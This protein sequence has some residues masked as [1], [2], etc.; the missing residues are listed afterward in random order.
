MLVSVTEIQTWLRCRRQHYLSSLSKENLTPITPKPALALGSLIHKAG[1]L[2]ILDENPTSTPTKFKDIFISQAAQARLAFANL[3]LSTFN[4]LPTQSEQD[5]LL[6]MEVLGMHMCQNYQDF[7]K[8]PIPHGYTLVRPEQQ[9]VVAIPGTEHCVNPY[10][11][12]PTDGYCTA[13]PSCGPIEPHYLAGQLD[14]VLGDLRDR[15]FVYERKTFGR[16]THPIHL[17][18]AWQF[19]AYNWILRQTTNSEVAGI[20]YDGLWK[21]HGTEP[22]WQGAHPKYTLADLFLRHYMQHSMSVLEEFE[23]GLTAI[24]NE[25]ANPNTQPYPHVPWQTCTDCSYLE[26][27]DAITMDEDTEQILTHYTHRELTP[28]FKDF[29]GIDEGD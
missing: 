27:C 13:G 12:K 1:E 14:A 18:R 4:R 3:Y 2:W 17:N 9:V 11:N 10:C 8:T 15:L 16:R 21:R 19:K 6:G 25:M 28:A 7:Y 5:E 23:V 24:V 26:L 22:S 29:Y 20:L